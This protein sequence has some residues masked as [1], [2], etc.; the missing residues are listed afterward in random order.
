MEK[1][2]SDLTGEQM[3]QLIRKMKIRQCILCVIAEVF[4]LLFIVMGIWG[5]CTG[6][7]PAVAV[8]AVILGLGGAVYLVVVFR[9]CLRTVQDPEHCRLFRK[10]GS[11]STLAAQIAAGYNTCIIEN[12]NVYVTD[13]F[14]MKKNDFDSFVPYTDIVL[15]Y[16]KE[17]RTNGIKD[18]VFLTVHDAYGDVFDYPFRIRKKFEKEMEQTAM[19][20]AAAAP[21]C[22]MGYTTENLK[23]AKACKKEL[24]PL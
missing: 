10:F 15:L 22:R 3:C 1:N 5:L 8:L 17:H 16:R 11:P 20:I 12:R 23:Y 2:L 6:E 19:R 7:G 14:I 18:G 21:L 4:F 24:P 9:R 13:T